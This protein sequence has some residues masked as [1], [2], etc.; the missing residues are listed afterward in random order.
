[1]DSGPGARHA[2][3]GRGEVLLRAGRAHRA[4][5]GGA[6]AAARAGDVLP[7]LRYRLEGPDGVAVGIEGD[8]LVDPDGGRFALR[9]ELGPGQLRPGLV[10]AHDHLHRNHYPRLGNPPYPDA[11][12]WGRDLHERWADEIARCRALDRREALLFGA[13]K[14]L[15]G[16]ATTVVHHDPWEPDFE[17]GFPVNVV[18][19]HTVHSLGIEPDL[20]GTRSGDPA[21]PLCIYL[22]EGTTAAAGEE[23]RALEARGLLDERLI[24]VHAVGVD[25]DGIGRLRDARAAVVWCPTS[26]GFLLGRTAPAELLR[27][28]VDVLLGCDS[29]LTGAGTLL[30]ELRAARS[31]GGLDD[32]TLEA[33]VGT[34]AAARLGRPTPALE[35]GAPADLVHLGRLLFE[36][37]TEDVRLVIVAGMPRLGDER[38]AELFERRGVAVERIRVGKTMRL[39]AAPLATVAERVVEAWPECG[40]ILE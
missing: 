22:A 3:R 21:L 40:R 10:N 17:K 39:V 13:L 31:Y 33:A 4:V 15:L 38:F 12:A 26:N 2:G 27:C 36:A 7:S 19:V 5:R 23:V 6:G 16:G 11:Y 14:N 1:M 35:P 28:G 34:T 25:R 29:L 20:G 37:G 18:R 24:A 8:R 30:D 9:A 32:P